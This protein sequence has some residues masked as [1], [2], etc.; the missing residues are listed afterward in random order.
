MTVPLDAEGEPTPECNGIILPQQ[1]WIASYIELLAARIR[2]NHINLKDLSGQTGM[3]RQTLSRKLKNHEFS[4]DELKRLFAALKIDGQCAMLAIEYEGDWR[5]YDS[6]TLE[7]AAALAK[8]LPGEITAA[9]ERDIQPLK[10]GAIRQL[11][12]E[13]AQRIALHDNEV[14]KRRESLQA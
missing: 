5:M 7:L 14:L 8:I 6:N 1:Q 4:F 12:R 9:L 2:A 3:S 11:A 10:A 13:V